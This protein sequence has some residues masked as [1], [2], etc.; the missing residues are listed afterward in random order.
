YRI[1]KS[2]EEFGPTKSPIQLILDKIG[3]GIRDEVREIRQNGQPTGV[4]IGRDYLLKRVFTEG[5]I[6]EVSDQEFESKEAFVFA[7]NF[8]LDF[9]VDQPTVL[10]FDQVWQAVASD[11]YESL[12]VVK[13]DM[14]RFGPMMAHLM[15]A[16]RETV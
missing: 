3:R 2:R 16:T 1:N 13:V 11:P 14:D 4:F 8:F 6:E 7:A 5:K 15:A 12:P 10:Q 9:R